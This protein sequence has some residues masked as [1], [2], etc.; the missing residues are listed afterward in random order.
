M[1]I[2]SKIKGYAEK[3]GIIVT[4]CS[5]GIGQATAIQLARAG[6]VVFA[7]VRKSEDAQSL[8][9]FNMTNLVPVCPLDL[10][11]RDEIAKT[12]EWVR[13]QLQIRGLNG[14]YGLVNNAGGSLVGPVE[15]I[16]LNKFA[17]ELDVR[18]LGSVAM[19]QAFLPLLRQGRGRIVWIVTP[20][21]IPTPY[22]TGIHACDF[23]V[24][25]ISR[26]LEIE[27]KPWQIPN[28]MIRCGG[29]KTRAGMNTAADL[30]ATLESARP[31]RTALYDARLRAWG[32]SMAEF[33]LKR[34]E[35]EEV[36][37]LV[38]RSFLDRNPRRRYSIGYLSRVASVLELLPQAWTDAILKARF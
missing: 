17:R 28:I 14:L 35:P 31:K 4:G 1:E 26:T 3:R 19:I 27:L 24:N 2:S 10:N 34:T 32:K 29:I 20:A 25:C 13:E 38:L 5:S 37:K 22:V 6:F 21:T 36:G 23:A 9:S 12:A 16:D 18:I 15:L 8:K 33:D 11:H 30:D 7:T